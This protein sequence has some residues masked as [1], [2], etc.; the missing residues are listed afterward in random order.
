[1]SVYTLHFC[2]QFTNNFLETAAVQVSSKQIKEKPVTHSAASYH[3]IHHGFIR[4]SCLEQGGSCLGVDNYHDPEDDKKQGEYSQ[5][6][7]PEPEEQVDL[8]KIK[9]E[10]QYTQ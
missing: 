8:L 4:Y 3:I 10:R 2:S 6:D 7:E 9:I 1:M 5:D